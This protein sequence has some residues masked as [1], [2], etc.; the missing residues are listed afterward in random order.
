MENSAYAWQS[1]A[2]LPEEETAWEIFGGGELGRRIG[3]LYG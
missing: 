1:H 2:T 3:Q